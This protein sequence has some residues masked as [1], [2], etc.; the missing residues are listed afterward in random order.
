MIQTLSHSKT[1]RIINFTMVKCNFV[2]FVQL[3]LKDVVARFNLLQQ[4]TETLSR[5]L[6]KAVDCST[7]LHSLW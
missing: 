5:K 7:Q 1:C 6:L 2:C 4:Q 3:E